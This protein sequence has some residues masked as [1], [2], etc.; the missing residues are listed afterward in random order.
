MKTTRIVVRRMLAL[1]RDRIKKVKMSRK[2]TSKMIMLQMK[3][4]LPINSATRMTP[5][6]RNKM[7]LN[8]KTSPRTLKASTML[9][10]LDK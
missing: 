3:I 10:L 1:N 9:T 5:R 4:N 2:P 8:L 7:L 6:R